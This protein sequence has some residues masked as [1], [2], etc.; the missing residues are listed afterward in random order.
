MGPPEAIVWTV[1]IGFAVAVGMVM[2]VTGAPFDWVSLNSKDS[3]HCEGVFNPLWRNE[4]SMCELSVVR[5]GDSLA[6][7]HIAPESPSN[8]S[9]RVGEWSKESKGVD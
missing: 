6:N 3:N 4:T 2:S 8:S 7:E 1:G 9:W 5:H